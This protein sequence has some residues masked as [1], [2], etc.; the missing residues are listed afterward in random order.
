KLEYWAGVIER[1]HDLI[2]FGRPPP[3]A[4][5]DGGRQY[6]AGVQYG[7][8]RRTAVA[9]SAHSLFIDSRRRDY[10]ELSLQRS[11]GRMLLNLSGAQ[12][13]GRGRAYRA[14]LLGQFG[15]INVQAQSFFVDGGSISGLVGANER[16]A[17]SLSVESVLRLGRMPVPV[18]GGLRR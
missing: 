2:S 7:V 6:A 11:L 3:N 9:A 17:H 1:N 13:L 16:S 15:R 8:D 4:L 10:A 18:S 12:E 5:F 14:D